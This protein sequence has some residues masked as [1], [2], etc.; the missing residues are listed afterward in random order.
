MTPAPRPRDDRFG[1]AVLGGILI[2]VGIA[3]LVL[4]QLDLDVG[5]VG[6]PFFVIVPGMVMLIVGLVATAGPGLAIGGSLITIAGLLRAAFLL[7]AVVR[8]R[9]ETDAAA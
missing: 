1:P 3:F 7:S 4:Q 8:R 9:D 2:V 5:R 6:W